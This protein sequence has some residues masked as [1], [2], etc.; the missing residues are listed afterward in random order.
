MSHGTDYYLRPYGADG[1]DSKVG[2]FVQFIANG[3]IVCGDVCSLVVATSGTKVAPSAAGSEAIMVG[4]YEGVGGSGAVE[5]AYLTAIE[6]ATIPGTLRTP[7]TAAAGDVVTL[8][9]K[10]LAVARVLGSASLAAGEALKAGATAGTFERDA[11]VQLARA[12]ADEAYT[13]TSIAYK[14]VLVNF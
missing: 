12:A 8:R 5:T 3:A 13:T 6:T 4:V 1:N 9:K 10:G 2:E 11:T 14:K 7:R